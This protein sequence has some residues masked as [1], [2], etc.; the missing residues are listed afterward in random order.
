MDEFEVDAEPSYDDDDGDDLS[1]DDNEVSPEEDV[2]AHRESIRDLKKIAR[3][4][5][6]DGGV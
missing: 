1:L 6:R 5:E 3:R 4:L 2:T